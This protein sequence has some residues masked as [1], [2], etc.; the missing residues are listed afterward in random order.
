MTFGIVPWTTYAI[1]TFLLAVLM[2]TLIV[3]FHVTLSFL[4]GLLYIR[5]NSTQYQHNLWYNWTFQFI[6]SLYILM[7]FDF[8]FVKLFGKFVITLISRRFYTVIFSYRSVYM[9]HV[10]REDFI[11]RLCQSWAICLPMK[12]CGFGCGQVKL[13]TKE[14]VF[15]AFPL[16]SF[17]S[18]GKNWLMRHQKNVS[19]WSDMSK[20][21]LL[22]VIYYSGFLHQNKCLTWPQPNPQHFIGRHIAQL[23]HSILIH[24]QPVFPLIS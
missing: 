15:I 12:C 24:S 8:P 10:P 5:H 1:I 14:L 13:K 3:L 4:L 21:W 16:P 23:W 19:E 7:S 2:F 17:R 18:E 20:C 6:L 9:D 11:H 22:S